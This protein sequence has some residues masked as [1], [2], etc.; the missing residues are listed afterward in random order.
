MTVPIGSL[1]FQLPMILMEFEDWFRTRLA[2]R[3][4]D[5]QLGV[6]Q[7]LMEIDKNKICLQYH[8]EIM[9]EIKALTYYINIGFSFIGQ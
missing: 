9:T 5:F 2:I 7:F 8:R 3:Q 1:L 6:K 4:T